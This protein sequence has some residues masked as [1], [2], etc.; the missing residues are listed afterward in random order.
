MVFRLLLKPVS[1]LMTLTGVTTVVVA[2]ITKPEPNTFDTYFKDW[3]STKKQT[4]RDFPSDI[5]QTIENI[6]S[7]ARETATSSFVNKEMTNL[8]VG[9]HVKVTV[10]SIFSAYAE[11]DVDESQFIGAFNTW[12][13]VSDLKD[14]A[15]SKIPKN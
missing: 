3:L 7:N 6:K 9:Y 10:P 12:W 15:I 5:K 14:Y 11:K 1:M 13:S 4:N 8:Y 2:V